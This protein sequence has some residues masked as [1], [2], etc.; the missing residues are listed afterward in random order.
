MDLSD[1]STS[2]FV[3]LHLYK[4]QEYCIDF[5]QALWKNSCLPTSASCLDTLLSDTA[6]LDKLEAGT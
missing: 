4:M 2:V 6:E 1:A 3:S 5:S